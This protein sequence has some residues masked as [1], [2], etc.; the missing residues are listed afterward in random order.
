MNKKIISVIGVSVVVITIWFGALSIVP[1]NHITGIIA[2]I[3]VILA[4]IK[5]YS[6]KNSMDKTI[7]DEKD[8][9]ISKKNEKKRK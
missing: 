5:W 7:A 1:W 2:G 4:F 3:G 8:H 9:R 6:L